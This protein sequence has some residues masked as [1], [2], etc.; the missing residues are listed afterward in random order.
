LIKIKAGDGSE[1]LITADVAGWR[2]QVS[3]TPAGQWL[4]RGVAFDR[5]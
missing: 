1:R 5:A 2:G 4:S 3:T